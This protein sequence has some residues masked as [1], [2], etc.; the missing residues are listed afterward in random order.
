MSCESE[1]K[2]EKRVR[3]VWLIMVGLAMLML[4]LKLCNVYGLYDLL[5]YKLVFF[6]LYG[7]VLLFLI[8]IIWAILTATVKGLFYMIFRKK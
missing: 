5:S 3:I 2:D 1:K 7:P 6:P 8:G 4:G